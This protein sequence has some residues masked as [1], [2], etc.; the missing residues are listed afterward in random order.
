MAAS[1]VHTDIV[2]ALDIAVLRQKNGTRFEVQIAPEWLEPLIDAVAEG[3]VID[4]VEHFPFLDA[5]LPDAQR[6]WSA[7]VPSVVTSG[8]WVEQPVALV[9]V[10]LQAVAIRSG[11]DRLL[12]LKWLGAEFEE[13]REALTWARS[14]RLD[15]DRLH[16]EIEKKEILLHCIVHDLANPLSGIVGALSLINLAKLDDSTRKYVDICQR[17][18]GDQHRLIRSILD[19]FSAELESPANAAL[20]PQQVPLAEQVV[21]GIVDKLQPMFESRSITL[22]MDLSSQGSK[23]AIDTTSLER[24][25]NNLLENAHRH[26]PEGGIVTVGLA[27]RSEDLEFSV[28]DKGRGVPPEL[29]DGLFEKFKQGEDGRGKSGLGLYFCKITAERWGGTVGQQNLEEGGS[30]FWIR[31]PMLDSD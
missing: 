27:R 29:G 2:E 18:T 21:R 6:S 4:V 11:S 20:D 14:M 13:Q 25:L 26:S 8:V 16:K 12:L 7:P 10:P 28:D 30:R 19:V 22:V 9:E 17:L 15:H 1:G 24:M 31:L 5:F 23:A 3:S